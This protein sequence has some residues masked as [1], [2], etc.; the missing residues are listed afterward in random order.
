MFH[1]CY[2]TIIKTKKTGRL[3]HYFGKHSTENIDDGYVGSGTII[4]KILNRKIRDNYE[5][6]KCNSKFFESAEDAFEFEIL[7]I[8]EG[9]EKYGKENVLNIKN[10]GGGTLPHSLYKSRKPVSKETRERMSESQKGRKHSKETKKLLSEKSKT[11]RHSDETKKR[12]SEM[13]TGEGSP[14]FKGWYKTPNGVFPSSRL[15]ATANN[16]SQFYIISHCKKEDL[17]Y[18]FIPKD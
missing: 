2:H 6:V 12:L 11:L 3:R 7:L 17:G 4:S 14:I 18:E 5:I 15:A 10:G 13:R 9:R 1:F 16:V 8:S